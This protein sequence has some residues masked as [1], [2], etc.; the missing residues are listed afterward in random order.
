MEWI[1]NIMMQQLKILMTKPVFN[2]PFAASE[3]VIDDSDFMSLHHQLV[4]QVRSNKA[5]TTSYLHSQP[6]L[7]CSLLLTSGS[8]A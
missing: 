1:N 4:D 5:G 8:V 3:E 6:A 2:I 7:H